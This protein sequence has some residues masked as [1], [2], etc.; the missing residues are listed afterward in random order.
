MGGSGA[1]PFRDGVDG[2]DY[3]WG[4]LRNVPAETIENEM[5]ILIER[6]TLRPDSM[7]A[8]RWRGGAGIELEVKIFPPNA[9]VASRAMER[10]R[11]QP[12]GRAGGGPG[13]IG[14]THLNPG[15]AGERDIGKI[16]VLYLEPGDV[17]RVGTQGGG[18]YGDPLDREPERVRA[19][20]RAGLVTPARA[21]E[22]YGVVTDAVRVDGPATETLRAERRRRRPADVPFFGF[23][24]EREGYERV[25]PDAL[26]TALVHALAPYPGRLQTFLCER[27]TRLV[28]ERAAAGRP[29]GPDEL[30]ELV[31]ATLAGLRWRS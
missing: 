19:D 22:A 8:G 6:Y 17:L 12:W 2:I 14:Y 13:S 27:V 21:R 29:V 9:S 23:G 10:Y 30:P 4:F 28:E 3:A 18:G 25:W 7:G 26:R 11:F 1:R 31:T 15:T 20:V 24:P 16:D 5:P